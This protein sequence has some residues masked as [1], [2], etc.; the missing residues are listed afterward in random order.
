MSQAGESRHFLPRHAGAGNGDHVVAFYVIYFF[1]LSVGR[2]VSPPL[3]NLPAQHRKSNDR[4]SNANGAACPFARLL[5]A[6]CCAFLL[7]CPHDSIIQISEKI[8]AACSRQFFRE[9]FV[10][11]SRF[12]YSATRPLYLRLHRFR[13]SLCLNKPLIQYIQLL[14]NL[15]VFCVYVIRFHAKRRA[16]PRTLKLAPSQKLLPRLPHDFQNLLP[17]FANPLALRKNKSAIKTSINLA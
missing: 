17:M 13:A 10:S 6:F 15:R 12:L 2:R 5:R 8:K 3:I 11:G 16:R 14:L 1:K 7:S 9:F 4:G